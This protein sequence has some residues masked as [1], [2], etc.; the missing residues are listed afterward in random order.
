MLEPNSDVPWPAGRKVNE[1]LIQMPPK[2]TNRITVVVENTTDEEVILTA[3]TVLGWLHAVDAI[4]TLEVR[5][6]PLTEHQPK[7]SQFNKDLPP[8]TLPRAQESEE[9]DPP[10]NL[11]HLPEEQQERARQLLTAECL[12]KMTGI[13]DVSVTLKWTFA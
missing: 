3:R 9:W 7:S 2:D 10:V 13:L 11:S 4:H 12:P 8:E 5:P 6:P 1:Q